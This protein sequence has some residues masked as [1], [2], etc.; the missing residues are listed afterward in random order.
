MPPVPWSLGSSVHEG[1]AEYHRLLQ[2]EQPIPAGHVQETFLNAWQANEDRQ[3]IQFKD[4]EI[5]G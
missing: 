3:P 4:S 5:Q 1:L 2:A